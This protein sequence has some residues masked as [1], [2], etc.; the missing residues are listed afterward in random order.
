MPLAQQTWTPTFKGFQCNLVVIFPLLTDMVN[1][2]L[3]LLFSMTYS[4][5]YIHYFLSENPME[6]CTTFFSLSSGNLMS[7]SYID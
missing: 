6:T 1:E 3:T 4:S 2:P 7:Y 5:W